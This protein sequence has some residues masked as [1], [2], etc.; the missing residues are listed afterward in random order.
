MAPD[1]STNPKEEH[2]P[3]EVAELIRELIDK[4]LK[5]QRLVPAEAAQRIVD[6]MKRQHP[7]ELDEWLHEHAVSFLTRQISHLIASVRTQAMHQT[8]RRAFNDAVA[9]G[10]VSL[11]D[12]K[13]RIDDDNTRAALRDMT[14]VECRFAADYHA[15]QAAA[16]AMREAF[17]R[18][19]AK[20]VGNKKVGDVLGE[21][22]LQR[23]SS[24][25]GFD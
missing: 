14:G 20:K 22:E 18:A 23:I 25:V 2:M 8:Q 15:G 21:E 3:P 24:Q 12:T 11:L 19:V 6:K 9:A 13:W 7:D 1:R 10:D 17:L 5:A 4:E 16:N